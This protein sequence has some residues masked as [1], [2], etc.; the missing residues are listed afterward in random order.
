[1]SKKEKS[2]IDIWK[3]TY[4]KVRP[5][6]AIV[7]VIAFL[8]ST[9]VDNTQYKIG[10]L[11]TLAANI[12]F[13]IFDLATSIKTRLDKIDSNFREPNPPDYI[14]FNAALPVIRVLLN[15]RLT[16]N[17]EVKIRILA[18]SAQF[19]WTSLI[20]TT[21]PTLFN[22]TNKNQ[23]III[24]I[25]VVKPSVLHDWGQKQ[26][27]NNVRGT[28]IGEGTFK[29]MYQTAFNEGKVS[30]NIY[31]YDNIPHWHGIL[32]DNDVL[33]MGRCKWKI[34]DGKY[35]LMVGQIDYRQFREKDKFEGKTRIEL[36]DNW[37]ETYKFRAQKIKQN[38]TRTDL[39]N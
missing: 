2:L 29:K 12:I 24:E 28:L 3:E 36:V 8:T 31:Q 20:E 30:L 13:L 7:L 1:M 35:H 37:F 19:S 15:E 4:P 21:I 14:D 22:S 17:K 5:W 25:V 18:V 10:L 38:K 27:E 9:A 33:F 34:I 6:V 32:I 16:I 23:K 26:L 39:D 11:S